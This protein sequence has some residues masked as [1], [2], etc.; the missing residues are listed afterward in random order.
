MELLGEGQRVIVAMIDGL[1][2]DYFD[3]SYMPTLHRLREEAFYRQVS[4]VFPSVTN[5]NNVSICCGAWP[6]E[7]GIIGNSYLD[8]ATGKP[9]YMNSA[10][11]IRAKTLFQRAA[12]KGVK[13]AILTS[14]RK[15]TELFKYDTDVAIAAERPSDEWIEKLGQPA[16]IYSA[17]INYWLWEAAIY[18]LEYRPDLG[19]I[20]VHTTDYP[21]HTWAEHE[22][23]SQD[24]CAKLDDLIGKARETAPDAA[25]FLTADHG[26]NYKT[27]CWDL[28]RALEN[29]DAPVRFVLSPERDYYIQHH[30]NFAGCAF[31][32]LRK[33][34]DLDRVM[35]VLR[36]LDGVEMA[37]ASADAAERFHLAPEHLGDIVVFGDR[38]TM[39]GDL[40]QENE[41]LAANY[42]NHGSLHEMEV[43][44][45]ID[46][47]RGNA[48]PPDEFTANKDLTR[49]LFR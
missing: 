30:R 1:G 20:Y 21:M 10:D 6:E 38:D 47:C 5:V 29:R 11:M 42:R 28:T 35:S 16:D 13:S 44:L 49:L 27:H 48:P 19:V 9:E 43:P 7:H 31:V 26:M 25:L 46:N 32:F 15:T 12:A 36:G 34:R 22:P 2:M 37:L 8:P 4:A 45:I 24:H 39:F 23:E 41:D 14:K 17:E 3:Q 40:E 33:P 18:L